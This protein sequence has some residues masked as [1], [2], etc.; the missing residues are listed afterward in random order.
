MEVAFPGSFV[1]FP[2]IQKEMEYSVPSAGGCAARGR[3]VLLAS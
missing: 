3:G 2:F 1:V